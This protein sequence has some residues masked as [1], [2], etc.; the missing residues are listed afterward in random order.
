MKFDQ[1]EKS[2]LAEKEQ[3]HKTRGVIILTDNR[4]KFT[5]EK[6][7]SHDFRESAFKC[8]LFTHSETEIDPLEVWADV[9]IQHD[10]D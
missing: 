7:V 6:K 2:E 5:P 8:T 1:I 4:P 10:E 9:A 3:K